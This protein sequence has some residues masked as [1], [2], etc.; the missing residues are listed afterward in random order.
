MKERREQGVRREG[1]RE[2]GGLKQDKS[3]I[4]RTD[5]RERGKSSRQGR[6]SRL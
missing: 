5:R 6:N 2:G 3:S 4:K 1:G